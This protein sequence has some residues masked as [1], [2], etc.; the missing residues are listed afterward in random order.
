MVEIPAGGVLI[1][2]GVF[3][4]RQLEMDIDDN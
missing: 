2:D 1:I 4:K 3:V